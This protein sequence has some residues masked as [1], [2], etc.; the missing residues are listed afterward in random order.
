[1]KFARDLSP[2]M[3][4]DMN[5]NYECFVRRVLNHDFVD[6]VLMSRQQSREI[7]GRYNCALS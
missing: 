5:V 4:F 1:M 2:N 6:D 7:S 3:V